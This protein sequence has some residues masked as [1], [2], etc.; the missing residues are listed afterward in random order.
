[1]CNV[2]IIENFFESVN[3]ITKHR[4]IGPMLK[5][6]D[7]DLHGTDLYGQPIRNRKELLDRYKVLPGNCLIIGSNLIIGSTD[8][9]AHFEI[10]SEN[11]TLWLKGMIEFSL[12]HGRIKSINVA[13]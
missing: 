7:E 2:R 10:L 3:L 9:T 6:L 11:Q 13:S 4:D 1:M 12:E 5:L 8:V